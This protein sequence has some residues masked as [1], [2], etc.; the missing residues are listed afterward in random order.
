MAQEKRPTDRTAKQPT[1][2]EIILKAQ[3]LD[4]RRQEQI[5][6]QVKIINRLVE[7]NQH[8]EGTLEEIAANYY[9]SGTVHDMAREALDKVAEINKK[10]RKEDS[11]G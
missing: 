7:I 11:N 3:E 2:Q 8:Y 5:Q 9:E 1:R 10:H 4:D 6:N